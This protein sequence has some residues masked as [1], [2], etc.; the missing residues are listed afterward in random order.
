MQHH[1]KNNYNFDY[2]GNKGVEGYL[3]CIFAKA[4]KIY[5]LEENINDDINIFKEKDITL[6]HYADYQFSGIVRIFQFLKHNNKSAKHMYTLKNVADKLIQIILNDENIMA[7]QIISKIELIKNFINIT[8]SDDFLHHYAYEQSIE[9]LSG[10]LTYKH[11]NIDVDDNKYF[12]IERKNIIVDYSSPNV[13]KNLHIGHL[14]STIIGESITRLLKVVG[15]N[16]TGIN[17]IGDWGTQ[18]GM[19]IN[20][21]K[22]IYIDTDKIMNY[23]AET[24]SAQLMDIYRAA[25]KLFDSDSQFADNSRKQT[26]LLQQGDSINI[27]IWKQICIIS[28]KEY[29]K[30]YQLLNVKNLMECGESYYQYLIPEVLQIL[31]NANYIKEVSGAKMIHLENWTIPLIIVKSDG[32]YTYDTTDLAAL[33]YRL[34]KCNVDHVIYITDSGQKSHFDMC[35]EI[36]NLIGWT[37]YNKK[38][39]HIGFG[40]VCGQDKKKLKTRSGDVMKM[41]DVIADVI[42]ES[43][44]I[45]KERVILAMSDEKNDNLYYKNLSDEDML[46]ISRK[47]GINTLKYFDLNHSYSSNYNYDPKIMFQ[48]NGNTGV[49]LMYCYARINGII[50]KS[51]INIDRFDKIFIKQFF[52]KYFKD[53]NI[54]QKESKELTKE[55]HALMLHIINLKKNL[56]NAVENFDVNILVKY[57]ANL[58]VYFN[59]FI[60]QKDGKIIESENEYFGIAMCLITSTIIEKLFD[61]LSF[62]IVNHM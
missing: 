40:V 20:Y 18:F 37:K 3:Y 42:E 35:F 31:E 27:C 23:I 49:Y 34:I 52:M 62:E 50:E 30:I 41:Y 46:N 21:L 26:Y 7:H 36:A 51:K 25:K 59:S 61:I 6:S 8:I 24:T 11:E 33:Y 1:N 48:F 54:K 39:T 10:C 9:I 57:L 4:I 15:H 55:T 22:I 29:N 60:S 45:I 19:I 44:K 5:F 43:H 56:Y 2:I 58:C 32:G 28:S 17:H 16:V 14:R 12:D 38:L 13:A 53:D 47:I